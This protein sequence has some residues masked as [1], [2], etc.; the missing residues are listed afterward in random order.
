MKFL[1]SA[2]L[3]LGGRQYHMAQREQDFYTACDQVFAAAQVNN[4]ALIVLAGDIFDAA[5]PPAY[6]VWLLREIVRKYAITVLGIDGNHDSASSDWLKV[7]GIVPLHKQTVNVDGVRFTGLNSMRPAMFYH[8][9]AQIPDNSADVLVLH[10]A[11]SELANAPFA[12]LSAMEMTPQ[13]RRIGVR[14]AAMGDIHDAAERRLG[15]IWFAYP[16]SPEMTALDENPDKCCWIV[17]MTASE[18]RLLRQPLRTRP[19]VQLTIRTQP[20]MD[21]LL[22]KMAAQ[23]EAMAVVWY[24]PQFKDFETKLHSQLEGR[25]YIARPLTTDKELLGQFNKDVQVDRQG[26]LGRQAEAVAAYFEEK[27]DAYQLT[28]AILQQPDQVDEIVK[29]YQQSKG[30]AG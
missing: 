15:N 4:A 30:L 13:L 22:M 9:L 12:E 23:P 5:K 6:A 10:Q 2:D 27:S 21:D 26:V 18:L 25:M 20:E 24:D 7:C 1:H 3:H 14:Y 8:E 19:V 17:D 11:V 16:G 28:S 29:K